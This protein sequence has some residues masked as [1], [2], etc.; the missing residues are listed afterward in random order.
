MTHSEIEAFLCIVKYK[1]ICAAAKA[2]CVTQ[3]ALSRRIQALE[4]ELGYSLLKRKKGVRTITL[5]EEGSAFMPIAEKWKHVYQEAQALATLKQKPILNLA[6][7]VSVSCYLLPRVLHRVVQQEN[8]NYNLYFHNLHS[9]EAYKQVEM[10]LIDLAFVSDD[11]YHAALHTIPAFQS[12][13][14]LVGGP[15]W[16]FIDSVHP[17]QL[18]PQKE[19]RFPWNAAFDIWHAKWF[20]ASILPQVQLDQPNLLPHFLTGENFAIAPLMVAREL[21]SSQFHICQLKDRPP[22]HMIYYLTNGKEKQEIIQNFLSYVQGELER[23]E[24]IQSFAPSPTN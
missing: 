17:K 24:G 19:I 4:E 8:K 7:V 5:T 9:A 15:Q 22:N 2:L 23:I 20:D 1:N 13:Y 12:P 18:N 11:M 14:V 6:S 3:P 10:G 21:D 16:R